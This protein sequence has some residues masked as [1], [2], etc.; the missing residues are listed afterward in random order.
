MSKH[1]P[2]HEVFY[3]FQGEGV[4]MGKS[5]FFI[6]TFGCPLHCPWCDSAG[7]WHKDFIPKQIDKIDV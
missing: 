6:R 1:I 4:H 5:A 7:T 2:I 3:A